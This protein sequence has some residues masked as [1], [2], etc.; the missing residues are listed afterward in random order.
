MFAIT[1]IVELGRIEPGPYPEVD[2]LRDAQKLSMLV[3]E[4]IGSPVTVD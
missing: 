1:M 2:A 3:G 4:F